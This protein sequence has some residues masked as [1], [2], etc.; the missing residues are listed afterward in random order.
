MQI[1]N[2]NTGEVVKVKFDDIITYFTY[3]TDTDVINSDAT[4]IKLDNIINNTY[5]ILR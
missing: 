3:G 5:T 2:I 4:Q 1:N